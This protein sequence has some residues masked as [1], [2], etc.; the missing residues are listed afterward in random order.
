[1]SNMFLCKECGDVLCNRCLIEK[2]LYACIVVMY[3][4]EAGQETERESERASKP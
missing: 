3:C 2:M 4:T 1:M